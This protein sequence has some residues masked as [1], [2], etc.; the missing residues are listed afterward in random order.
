MITN[1]PDGFKY[2]VLDNYE[3]FSNYKS[4]PYWFRDN[5]STIDNIIKQMK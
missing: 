5:L 4:V 2:F 1:Y 3:R